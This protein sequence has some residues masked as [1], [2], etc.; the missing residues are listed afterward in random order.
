MYVPEVFTPE[1]K[2]VQDL[3]ANHGSADLITITPDGLTGTY[4]PFTYRPEVGEHG[5]LVGHMSRANDHWR[6]PVQGEALVVVHGPDAYVTPTWYAT[7]E[8]THQV[9]PTWNYL[10]AHVYGRLTFHDDTAWIERHIRDLTEKHEAPFEK[11]WTVDE[12]PEKFIARQLRLVVGVELQITRIQGKLKMSQN[13]PKVD[14]P[15][16]IQGLA[17]RGDVEVAEAVRAANPASTNPDLPP[18]EGESRCS[19]V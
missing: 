19:T 14:V 17:S 8:E 5:T 6:H 13:R 9:V 1:E 3:L 12:A 7:K 15:C 18:F 4:M 11:Q 2:T 10:T 16:V